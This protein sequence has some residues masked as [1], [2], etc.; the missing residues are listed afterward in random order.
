MNPFRY[1]Q[2]VKK[3][4]F[5]QR[6]DLNKKLSAN[7]GRGQNV[8]I[9]GERRIGKTSLIFET[10]RKLKNYRLI[11]VDL[12]EVKSSDSFLKRII[13]AFISLE[14]S[15]GFTEKIFKKLSHLKPIASIDPITN[16]PT[17]SLDS[18]I[19]FRPDSIPGV[20]DLISSYHS[21]TKPVVVVFDEFQDILNLKDATETLAIL[22]SRVQ[23]QSGIP[24]IFSGSIRNKMDG[25]FND[26]DSAFFKS[27]IPIQVGPIDRDKFQKFIISKFKTG[28]RQI[29]VETLD[30]IFT[31]CFE[32]PGDIQQLCSA[33]WETTSAD[34]KIS[35][36]YIP[37][38]LEQ[39]F[40]HE[41]KGYE[42]TLNIITKQQLKMLTGLARLGG[43]APMSS[44][45][46][47]NSGI[48]QPSSVQRALSRVID[49][50]IIFHS[51]NE[52]RFV[53]PFF[54]AW[55]LYKKF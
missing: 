46:L 22:R 29:T 55:L 2:I 8:Y 48:A 3:E 15:T 18:A 45:F 17:L 16:L 1:G 54:R 34:S 30:T 36:D 7:I 42:T 33:L 50:K 35:Q 21:K 10:I 14:K 19:E 37:P 6:P 23:F 51:E 12:L 49:L 39:V 4:D 53:N 27:A 5:C 28:T 31:I 52:Y 47:K 13:T 9:Q 11:Y 24:Y 44:G 32:I 38:A 20:V 43:K 40:S 25:I 41:L 26:P